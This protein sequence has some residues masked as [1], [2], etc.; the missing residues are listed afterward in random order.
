MPSIRLVVC[1]KKVFEVVT[2]A[3]RREITEVILEM[4]SKKEG[5]TFQAPVILKHALDG[6]ESFWDLLELCLRLFIPLESSQTT[7]TPELG[8]MAEQAWRLESLALRGEI[9]HL[10]GQWSS[11]T[12]ILRGFPLEENKLASLELQ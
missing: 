6:T 1:T 5:G 9:P 8:A 10:L 11:K 3:A 2:K 12:P 7:P 4:A